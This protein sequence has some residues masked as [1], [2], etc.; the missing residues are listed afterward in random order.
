MGVRAHLRIAQIAPIAQPVAPGAGDSIEQLVWLLCE[1]LVRRGHDVTLFAS[2]DSQTSARLRSVYTHGYEHDEGLWDWRLHESIN[3]AAAFERSGEFDVI[4]SHAYHFALPFARLV[5]TPLVQS[6]HV[7]IDQDILDAYR[8]YPEVQLIA[9]SEWQRSTMTGAHNVTVIHNGIDTAAFPFRG[10]GGDY[11][12]FLGRMIADKGPVEAIELARKLELPLVLAGA[13]TDYFEQAVRPLIDGKQV[14]YVGHVDH[15]HRNELLASA[16]AL[17]LPLAYPEPFG[18]VMI[19][20]MA[21][22]TPVVATD[23]GAVGEIVEN[24]VSGCHAPSPQA[25]AGCVTRALSLDR[26]M[27]R[28]RAVKRFDFKRMVDEHEALYEKLAAKGRHT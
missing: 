28:A 14:R 3:A 8:R 2:G 22:G 4:H 21:C 7:A 25:L 15:E 24:G 20:A 11:L 17:L 18:L 23:I 12:L 5:A 19:E 27:I 10:E 13:A 1:E 9:I 16:G 6:Y 26:A